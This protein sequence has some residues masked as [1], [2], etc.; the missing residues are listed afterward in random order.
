MQTLV[1]IDTN[2]LLDFYRVRSRDAGLSILAKLEQHRGSLITSDQ[3]YMEF[4]KN[5]HSALLETYK[6]WKDATVPSPSLPPLLHEQ[7]VSKTLEKCRKEL[8]EQHRRVRVRLEQV[9]SNPVKH[10]PVF[11]GVG[12]I[13]RSL[14]E[15]HL[16]TE[17]E[18]AG[19]LQARALRRFQLGYPPRKAADTSIGD[20]INW[21]WI[22]ACAKKSRARIVV[23]SRDGDFGSAIDD[24]RVLND[25]LREEFRDR[26]GK[27]RTILLRSR[28][29]EAMKE[30]AI[31]LTRQERKAAEEILRPVPALAFSSVPA[32]GS[33]ISVDDGGD[34]L[35]LLHGWR[36]PR[37]WKG[38]S[39]ASG[40]AAFGGETAQDQGAAIED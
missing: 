28:I 18:G 2:I 8:V 16:S 23:V 11:R 33:A 19:E 9:F 38:L 30:L 31:P 6:A 35:A 32:T 20:A 15:W 7:K 1:F 14:S 29:T 10:D 12:S 34:L 27:K 3:V 13:M 40:S 21:E 26:V 24:Q 37:S 17:T 36:A 39:V 5:R 25:W 22:I 4:Q